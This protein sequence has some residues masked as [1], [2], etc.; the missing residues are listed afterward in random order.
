MFSL[1][2][3]FIFINDL[4]E[5][6]SSICKLYVDHTKLT[7]TVQYFEESLRIQKDL[8]YFFNGQSFDR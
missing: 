4:S 3:Q 1:A 8:F 5:L 6:C 7:I 2:Y